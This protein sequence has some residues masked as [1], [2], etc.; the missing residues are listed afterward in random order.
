MSAS[1]IHSDADGDADAHADRFI[2]TTDEMNLCFR[3]YGDEKGVPVLLIAGLGLQ[4]ISWPDELIR[5]LTSAGYFVIAADN[6]DTGRSSR[7][8]TKPPG[9]LRQLFAI[10]PVEN[11]SL[12]DMADDMVHLMRHLQADRVHVVGMSMGGMIAQILAY[13]YPEEVLSLTSIFSTTGNWRVGRPATSTLWQ[14][15]RVSAPRSSAEAIANYVSMM[16]HIGD[17]DSEGIQQAWS[18]YALRA[19]K[20][21]GN[22]P[23]A[24]GF[25]RQIGAIHKSG[26]RSAQLRHIKAP[27]LVLHGDVDLMVD[28]SGGRATA[29]A[30]PGAHFV[31]IKGMRHQIDAARSPQL[32]I[33]IVPHLH[34]ADA[35]R[36]RRQ[37]SLNSQ[38]LP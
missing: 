22:R 37:Q 21:N 11:Y 7:A 36:R 5:A 3:T 1:V 14:M 23:N 16:R 6:R 19:W 32:G 38:A 33:F 29:A 2:E 13:K 31:I 9:K 8:K 12:D 27:T 17:P 10:P 4:L 20:R 30:I 35:A 34:R 26:D 15:S 25:A 18:D 24:S 28:P